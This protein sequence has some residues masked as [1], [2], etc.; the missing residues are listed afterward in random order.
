MRQNRFTDYKIGFHRIGNTEESF[1]SERF[2]DLP[3]NKS[4]YMKAVYKNG[5]QNGMKQNG[6]NGPKL[7]P[8]VYQDSPADTDDD[9]DADDQLFLRPY[10]D[11]PDS[12]EG[13][14][15]IHS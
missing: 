7:S 5:K 9:D 14:G 6:M 15:H 1:L 4:P 13:A 2:E 12:D 10:K 3:S 8:F 11:Q